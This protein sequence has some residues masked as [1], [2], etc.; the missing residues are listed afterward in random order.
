MK[1]LFCNIANMTYYKGLKPYDMPYGG[2]AYV[3]KHYD[4]SDVNNFKRAEDGTVHGFVM[5]RTL[6]KDRHEFAQIRL[7][8]IDPELPKDA[9]SADQVLVVWVAPDRMVKNRSIVVGWYKEAK[10]FRHFRHGE[11]GN[12]YNVMARPENVV[13]IAP[14]ERQWEVPRAS[15]DGAGSGMG[16]SNV[17]YADKPEAVDF[18][19]DL[20]KKIESYDG[21]NWLDKEVEA[22]EILT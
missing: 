7:E 11:D 9:D 8:K 6:K 14:E 18:V 1:I 12:Y 5:T 15:R 3:E 22:E 4:G 17:W 10:V 13:L 2:G 19:L 16:Q 20:L 21:E